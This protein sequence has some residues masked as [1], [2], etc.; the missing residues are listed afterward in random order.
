M[1]LQKLGGVKSMT[2]IFWMLSCPRN[3]L[4]LGSNQNNTD[5]FLVI[6]AAS[7]R[8]DSRNISSSLRQAGPYS[9]IC[10]R[11]FPEPSATSAFQSASLSVSDR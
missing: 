11:W 6:I 9:G 5:R 4:A 7:T 10:P 8:T 1:A 2:S 3:S